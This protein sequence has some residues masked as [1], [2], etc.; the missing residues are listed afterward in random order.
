MLI[1][2]NA[3]WWKDKVNAHSL[4]AF[5][6]GWAFTFAY[7][8]YSDSEGSHGSSRNARRLLNWYTPYASGQKSLRDPK[9]SSSYLKKSSIYEAQVV[10]KVFYLRARVPR[11]VCMGAE[12]LL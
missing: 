5:T 4:G 2:Y 6:L 7:L 9:K 1:H 12:N 10:Q 3:F 8:A 11:G